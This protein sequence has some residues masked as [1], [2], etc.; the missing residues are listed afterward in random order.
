[1]MIPY[2]A[3]RSGYT[4]EDG[5]EIILPRKIAAMAWKY[6]TAGDQPVRPA[7]LGARDVLRLEAALPLYGHELNE[8]IDPITAGLGWACRKDGGY[9]GAEAI[10]KV[11]A[12][13][14]DRKLVCLKLQGRRIARQGSAVRIDGVEA[15]A[16]TSGTFS[17]SCDGSIALAYVDRSR[18]EVGAAVTVSVRPDELADGEIVP[19]PFYQ[20]SAFKP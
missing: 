20:G 2:T 4:G 15:G 14:A 19:R 10:E 6:I 9:I 1:M 13:G 11:R 3:S 16:V 17:P 12:A 5:F 8:T 18:A 7:G